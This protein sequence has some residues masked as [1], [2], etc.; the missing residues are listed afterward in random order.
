MEQY[1]IINHKIT[2][3]ETDE[4]LKDSKKKYK[5][6]IPKRI[7][8]FLSS[9]IIS[10][11]MIFPCIIIAAVIFITDPGN[12]FYVQQRVGRYGKPIKIVK[13]RSMIKNADNLEDVLTPE[14]YEDYLKEFKLDN[15]PRL[16]PHNVG[17]YIRKLSIDE[18]P[19]ILFNICIK[20]DMSVVG[21]RPILQE[22]I[23]LNYSEEEQKLL[24][25]V[26]PGLTGYW[27]AYG[28]NNVCYDGGKRQEMELFY[29]QNC[30]IWFDIKIMFKTVFAV[31]KKEGA[32]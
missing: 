11:L 2:V 4:F 31:L 3:R 12:P 25:S 13:F 1:D 20:G 32:K 18:L 30:S 8:D 23:D 28:R 27:Q 22:E 21:P 19:Q 16:L 10:V 17:K 5:Y 29:A 7:F 24:L 26:K 15:D 6:E 14:Q 9:L